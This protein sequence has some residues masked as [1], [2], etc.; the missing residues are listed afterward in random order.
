M[1]PFTHGQPIRSTIHPQSGTFLMHRTF[2]KIQNKMPAIMNERY[3]LCQLHLYRDLRNGQFENHSA[4]GELA[5]FYRTSHVVLG[6]TII[7]SVRYEARKL[8][9]RRS[10]PK[11]MVVYSFNDLLELQ[12][13]LEWQICTWLGKFLKERDA[14]EDGI[15]VGISLGDELDWIA[16][17]DEAEFNS[18]YIAPLQDTRMV[19]MFE[20]LHWEACRL[21]D[22]PS[23][24]PKRVEGMYEA[25]IP[26]L[27][28]KKGERPRSKS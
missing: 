11:A 7:Q 2:P 15:S 19:S 13:G 21:K 16:D 27:V 5:E 23:Y 12:Y 4:A 18:E 1:S 8:M 6:S 3:Q 14:P 17:C 20:R 9:N 28:E 25:P 24:W 10:L 22:H 26:V